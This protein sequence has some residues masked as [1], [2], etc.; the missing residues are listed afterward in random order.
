MNLD[1]RTVIVGGLCER[2][3]ESSGDRKSGNTRENGPFLREDVFVSIVSYRDSEC[4]YTVLE[5]LQKASFRDRIYFGIYE[6]V[7]ACLCVR[8][9]GPV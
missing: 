9:R 7:C 6:Q 4:S 5:A 3:A 1:G 2:H 8:A